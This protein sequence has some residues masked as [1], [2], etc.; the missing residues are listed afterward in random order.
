[1]Q[2]SSRLVLMAVVAL[3][4]MGT[5][6]AQPDFSMIQYGEGI[7]CGLYVQMLKAD[8]TEA[9]KDGKPTGY[10]PGGAPPSTSPAQC[11]AKCDEWAASSFVKDVGSVYGRLGVTKVTGTCYL[12]GK[13]IAP[14]RALSK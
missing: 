12:Q 14:P 1:M 6:A 7:G 2:L 10:F 13:P 3:A 11:L 8:G 4:P 5:T 9:T